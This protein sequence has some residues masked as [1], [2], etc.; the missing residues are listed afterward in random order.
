MISGAPNPE[1]TRNDVKRMNENH[2]ANQLRYSLRVSITSL[3]IYIFYTLKKVAE[4]VVC[5]STLLSYICSC[6][7]TSRSF[8]GD[9]KLSATALP[10]TSYTDN[11]LVIRPN[12]SREQR[13]FVFNTTL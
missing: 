1:E 8:F 2:M 3:T 7:S 12:N 4:L 6:P 10:L 5:R 11:A 13:R 9:K